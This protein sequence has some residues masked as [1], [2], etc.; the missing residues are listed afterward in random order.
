MFMMMQTTYPHLNRW[1]NIVFNRDLQDLQLMLA[2]DVTF[3]SPYVWRPYQGRQ[4]T[5]LILTNV[6][7]VFQ[8]FVYHREL[9]DGDNWALE[10]SAKVGSLSLKGID[11]IRL[12]SEGQIVDFEV[13]VR[14]FNGLQALGA[15]MAQRLS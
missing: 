4:A 2:E 10:F 7:Q 1:H 3:R 14:P 15:A 11:L 13:F 9:I 12:N 5:W 6:L 8:D